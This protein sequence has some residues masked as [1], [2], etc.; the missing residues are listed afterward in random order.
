[1]RRVFLEREVTTFD[2]RVEMT[3]REMVELGAVDSVFFAE[4][5]FPKTMRQKSPAFHRPVWD[6]LDGNDRLV[7]LQIFRGGAKTSIC[8]VFGAKR[9]AYGNAHTVLWVGKSQD[10]ALHSVKWLRKQIEFN[11]RFAD[12]FQLRPGSKW[13]DVECEIIHGID[14]YPI[15]ILALGVTGSVRG[16]NIDDYRPDLIILDDILDEENTSTPVQRKKTEDLVYGALKE[17]LTPASE[18]PDAKMVLLQTPHNIEDVSMKSLKDDEWVH[19]RFS[20]WTRET[21]NSPVD[22]Q[23][24]SWPERFPSEVMR[25]EKKAAIKR[26]QLSIFVREKECRIISQETSAFMPHWLNFYDLAPPKNEMKI[27][28]TIDPVPPPSQVELDKGLKGK[29]NECLLVM[30]RKGPDFY[31]L[32][33]SAKTGHDPSW[34]IMEFFRLAMKWRPSRIIVESIAYQ[35]TLAWLLR[36]AMEQQRQY[37]VIFENSDKRSKYTKIVD[38]LSGA[39]SNGHLYVRPEHADF[40]QQFNEYPDVQH[41][42]VLECG[43]VAC[44]AL[45]GLMYADEEDFGEEIAMEEKNIK[46]LSYNRGAP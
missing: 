8:R 42:D 21:E 25:E 15:T 37:F 26:N 16:V 4:T 43:A 7:S 27:V 33:Y 40:I 24:S 45:Q 14:E 34:T 31:L 44:S 36:R 30:G 6:K 18:S 10:H 22:E 39:T 9:I 46:P 13:Q 5:F 29:D 20:C 3:P 17:S 12:T 1:M 11:H 28:M 32:E 38:G 2:A 23:E 19:E 35:R 41:D